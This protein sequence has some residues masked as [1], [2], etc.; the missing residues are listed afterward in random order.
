MSPFFT[1]SKIRG[2]DRQHTDNQ[3]NTHTL[4]LIDSTNQE[5]GGYTGSVKEHQNIARADFPKMANFGG[6]RGTIGCDDCCI[7][8]ATGNQAI[9]E[10]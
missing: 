9:E 3:T 4:R 8:A 10:T 7:P 6:G 1:V 5:A 2:G